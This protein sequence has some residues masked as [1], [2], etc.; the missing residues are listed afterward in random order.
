MLNLSL[1]LV[2]FLFLLP[3]FSVLCWFCVRRSVAR[4]SNAI[5]I[6]LLPKDKFFFHP[7]VFETVF[8]LSRINLNIYTYFPCFRR[9]FVSSYATIFDKSTLSVAG[10]LLICHKF[11]VFFFSFILCRFLCPSITGAIER[12]LSLVPAA[13]GY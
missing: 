10:R 4:R 6:Y 5:L 1:S 2:I 11:K 7:R 13:E 8:F 9:R 12:S 3:F